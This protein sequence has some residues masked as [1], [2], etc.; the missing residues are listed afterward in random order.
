MIISEESV[1]AMAARIMATYRQASADQ[2]A[3]GRNWYGV[4]NRLAS[5]VGNGDV[6]R[7]A[8]I[9]AA[10]SPQTPWSRNVKIAM[11]LA[12]GQKVGTLRASLAKAE[13][14]LAG[15]DFASVLPAEAKTWNF[16]HNVAGDESKVTVDRW[17]IRIAL[18]TD[19]TSVT[20]RQYQFI[21]AAYRLA[22]EA[23]GESPAAMQAIT[24]CVIRGTGE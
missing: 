9:I 8:G 2:L 22:A 7:G 18:G 12:S 15:E 10:L 4:A 13:R 6:R 16:A 3:D 23:A 17:A 19:K 5:M 14:I 21:A 24:W 1:P 20:A 11:A